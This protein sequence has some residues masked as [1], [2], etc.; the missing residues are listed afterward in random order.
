M[1]AAGCTSL[2]GS[3]PSMSGNSSGPL[4]VYYLDVG[5][6]DSALIRFHNTTILID[7]GETEMG[8]RVVADLQRLGVTRIDLLVATHAHSDHIG[9]M[10]AVLAAFPVG[11][12]LDAGVPSTSPVYEKFLQQVDKR[13]I[14]Y[15]VAVQGETIDLDPA[16]RILVLSPPGERLNDDLNQNSVVLKVSY[17]TTAFLFTGDMGGE[18]ETALAKSGYPLESQVLKVGHHGSYSSSSAAFLARVNPDIAVISLGKA[19]DYGH[20]HQQTLDRLAAAGSTIFRTDNDGTVRVISDGSSIGVTTEKGDAGFWNAAV[21]ATTP[22]VPATPVMMNVTLN[23]SGIAAA[24]PE[25]I[26]IPVTLPPIQL[27]NASSVYISAVQFDAPGDDRVNLN[28]EWV[29][30]ANRGSG[31]VLIAGWTLSDRTSSFTYIFPAVVLLPEETVTVYTGSGT[32]NDTSLF[33]GR[34]APVY[35]NSGDTAILRDGAGTIVDQK[36]GVW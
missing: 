20:P 26:T 32:M 2:P 8:D 17:G 27:G 11:R 18:A 6:G 34:S 25:N 29:R 19:N 7:A 24:L 5:Q 31:P 12:V 21:Y 28:G 15:T 3:T 14:P 30:V 23:T 16:L 22:I 13:Q 4:A 1:A 10:P 36:D 9:G 33:M 35:G